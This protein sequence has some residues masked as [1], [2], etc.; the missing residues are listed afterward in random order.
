MQ[1][2]P[3]NVER[4][5]TDFTV[6]RREFAA[7]LDALRKLEPLMDA[8]PDGPEYDSL[9]DSYSDLLS[10]GAIENAT[11]K[12]IAAVREHFNPFSLF[13]VSAALGISKWMLDAFI[14][15][16]RLKRLQS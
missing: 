10:R 1:L 2:T 3:A 6:S 12:R 8:L 15:S 7:N 4:Y 9:Y 14:F 16:R 11:L 5:V 13:D